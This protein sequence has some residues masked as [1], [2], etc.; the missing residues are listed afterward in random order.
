M[1]H[2]EESCG[3]PRASEPSWTT[4]LDLSSRRPLLPL[5]YR[6]TGVCGQAREPAVTLNADGE[7]RRVGVVL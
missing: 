1:T 7:L 6:V 5:W 2:I 4:D 3:E